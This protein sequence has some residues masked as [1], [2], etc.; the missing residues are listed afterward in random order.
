MTVKYYILLQ[1]QLLSL[2]RQLTIAFAEDLSSVPS[3]NMEAN[4]FS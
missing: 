1:K 3:T 4:N 2:D